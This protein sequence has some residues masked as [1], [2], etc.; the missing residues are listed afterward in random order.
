MTI[1]KF[2]PDPAIRQRLYSGPLATHIDAFAERLASQGYAGSTAREKLRLVAGLSRWLDRGKLEADHLNEQRIRQ[3]LDYRSRRGFTGRDNAAT[4]RTLLAHLREVGCIPAVPAVIN[5]SAFYSIESDYARYLSQERG[6]APAT[7][8]NY[9]PTVRR[10]LTERFGAGPP[11]LNELCP[12]DTHK[13]ILRHAHTVSP[14]QAK[15]LV[16]AL[17]SF[18]RYLYQHG[19]VALDL[20]GAIP[21]VANWRFTHLP[22]ALRAEQVEC[23]LESCDRSAAAGQ[24]DYA[25][26]LLLARL[27]LRAGEIVIMTLDDV[28]WETGLLT[29]RGKG[30]RHET[31][32][33]PQDVGDALVKYLRYVRPRCTTRRIFIRLKAPYQGFTSSVAICDIVRRALARTGLDPAFK[34]AHLLR[35]SLATRMLSN[36]AS[37]AEIGDILRHRQPQTTQIYAKVD[38]AALRALAQPWPGGVA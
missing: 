3:F 7:L 13:F 10:F 31:L 28:D 36:G 18:L 16:T 5:D 19:H 25:I 12:Q 35:H 27:G 22:K 11:K 24:R 33:L 20:A 30:L 23:L 14:A 4:C 17:R 38:V 15:L 6:L 9:L 37:L 34:G 8:L 2:F 1:E 26:L 29:I 32:P 21:S